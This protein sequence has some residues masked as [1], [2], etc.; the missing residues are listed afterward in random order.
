VDKMLMM[1][2]MIMMVIFPQAIELCTNQKVKITEELAEKLSPEVR[3]LV[4]V[5]VDDDD[6]VMMMMTMMT[7]VTVA[8]IL[9]DR[10]FT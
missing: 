6:D 5:V 1:V 2:M 8:V 4:V 7:T 9:S 3:T 10:R